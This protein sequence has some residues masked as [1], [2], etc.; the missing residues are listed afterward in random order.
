MSSMAAMADEMIG[1]TGV[2][3][4]VEADEHGVADESQPTVQFK[5]FMTLKNEEKS[6][7]ILCSHLSQLARTSPSFE[8]VGY[9]MSEI[10]EAADHLVGYNVFNLRQLLDRQAVFYGE[11]PV[12]P[13]DHE[14]DSRA[15]A[16]LLRDVLIDMKARV[17]EAT[18]QANM[19][20]PPL[21]LEERDQK[22]GRSRSRRTKKHKKSKHHKRSRSSSSGSASSS[23]S[24]SRKRKRNDDVLA[25]FRGSTFVAFGTDLLPSDNIVMK[26][27]RDNRRWATKGVRDV[28]RRPLEDFVPSYL[29]RDLASDARKKAIQARKS[30]NFLA[31]PQFMEHWM[32]YWMSHGIYGLITDQ[33][34]CTAIAVMTKFVSQKGPGVAIKY[35]RV[36]IPYINAKI[37]TMAEGEYITT[38]DPFIT[39]LN[40]DLLAEVK[41]FS[42]EAQQGQRPPELYRKPH[43]PPA[44]SPSARAKVTPVE[45]GHP[46]PSDLPC[47]YH[48]IKLG[49]TCAKWKSGQCRFNHLNTN[50]VQNLK[51]WD[52]AKAARDLRS[53]KGQGKGKGKGKT[54]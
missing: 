4:H 50:N 49:L 36:L 7:V 21:P 5:G 22:R 53:S 13:I 38:L 17:L 19:P 40:T 23:S 35:F 10:T 37:S 54:K 15:V 8:A 12:W 34:F 44:A 43:R 42:D 41:A 16:L 18:A 6:S 32:G 25:V 31:G 28:S 27:G 29:G 46:Q 26:I 51:I 3:T 2:D 1:T 45:A 39:T 14:E 24:G 52:Q 9:G 11:R 48:N 30:S 33:A 20:P 47:L